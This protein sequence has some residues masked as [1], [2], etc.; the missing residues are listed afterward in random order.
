MP[1]PV[2]AVALVLALV[3]CG[4]AQGSNL[5]RFAEDK[6]EA[7]PSLDAP[8][9]TDE[10]PVEPIRPG[11]PAVVAFWGSW[12]GPCRAEQPFLNEAYERYRDEVTFIG[13]DTRHDQRAAALAFIDEFD[14]PYG[15]I[16]DEDSTIAADWGVQIMPATIIVDEDGRIAAQIIGGIH[17][18]GQ[19]AELIDEVLS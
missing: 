15:S 8:T 7:A 10:L 16:V 17:S 14:V 12:C 11:R 6:R 4:T 5:I 9:L 3:A 19:I 13:V 1:R 18:T 2:A